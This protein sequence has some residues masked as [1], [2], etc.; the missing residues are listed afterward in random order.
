MAT[1]TSNKSEKTNNKKKMSVGVLVSHVLIMVGLL[2]GACYFTLMTFIAS[3]TMSQ[4]MPVAVM[5]WIGFALYFGMTEVL[6]QAMHKS[7]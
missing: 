7:T 6:P 5:L 1:V 2:L 3:Y 4:T